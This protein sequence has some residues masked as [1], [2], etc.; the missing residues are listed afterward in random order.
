MNKNYL[1]HIYT[2]Y[3]H[4]DLHYTSE[5]VE[6]LKSKAYEILLDSM[7]ALENKEEFNAYIYSV[8]DLQFR[9]KIVP[10]LWELHH[11]QATEASSIQ[12]KSSKYL[13][14]EEITQGATHI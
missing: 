3:G 9:C 4:L 12:L 1:L 5:T 2:S 13:S 7:Q 8:H 11:E 14:E 6:K 10:V